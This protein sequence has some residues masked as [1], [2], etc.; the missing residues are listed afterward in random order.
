MKYFIPVL[1]LMVACNKQAPDQ[2]YPEKLP[3]KE[4]AAELSK[5]PEHQGPSGGE[6]VGV[7][8]G[9]TVPFD[10][11]LLDETKAMAAANLR[12]SY[13]EIYRLSDVNRRYLISVIEIQEQE[14]Y[15][16]DK[17]IDEK[18]AALRKIRDSWWARHK[19]TMGVVIGVVCGMAGTVAAGGVWA[20]MDKE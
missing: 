5:L 7:A 3:I 10:G 4:Q 11:I 16:A 9:D 2:V 8:K 20:A 18:E 6:A 13:D 19:M 17:I 15:R 1:F 14:L 12:I